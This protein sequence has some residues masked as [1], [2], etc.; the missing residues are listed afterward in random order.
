LTSLY[1][2]LRAGLNHFAL[3]GLIPFQRDKIN[4]DH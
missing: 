2:R 4:A 1:L 3:G